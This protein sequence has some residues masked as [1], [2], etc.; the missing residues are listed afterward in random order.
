MTREGCDDSRWAAGATSTG[1]ER[2]FA[3]LQPNTNSRSPSRPI[4]NGCLTHR[5]YVVTL[6]NERSPAVGSASHPVP[7]VSPAATSPEGP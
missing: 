7:G 2:L 1:A 6:T 3:T 4:P 5:S